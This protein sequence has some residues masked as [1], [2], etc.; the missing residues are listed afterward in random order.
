MVQLSPDNGLPGWERISGYNYGDTTISG[1]S[2]THL[3]GAGV[4]DLYDISFMPVTLPYKEKKPPLGI[5]S[6]F[7]HN[8]EAAGAG[9]YQVLLK[10]YNINVELTATTRC[11]IQRY[12]FPR[13]EAAIFLNLRKSMHRDETLDSHIDVL[14]SRTIRGYRISD[15]WSHNQHVYF[16]TRF[17]RP[18]SAYRIDTIPVSRAGEHIGRSVVARFDFHTEADEQIIVSTA[19][20]AVSMDGAQANLEEEV[21]D[22]DF[23]EYLINAHTAWNDQLDKIEVSGN[24]YHDKVKFYTAMYHSMLEPTTY[25]DTNGMYRGPGQHTHR[26]Y[27]WVNYTTFALWDTYRAQHPFYALVEPEKTNDIIKSMI[28]FYEQSGSLPAWSLFG[29]ETNRFVGYHATSVIADAYMKDIGNFDPNKALEACVATANQ[30]GFRG[31]GTYKRL[32]YVPYDLPDADGDTDNNYALSKT[33]AYAYDDYCI[34]RMAEK[35]GRKDIAKEFYLRAKNYKNLYNPATDFIQPRDSRGKFIP[36]FHPEE[37]SPYICESNAWLAL[38]SAQHDAEGLIK[39]LGGSERFALKLDS[40]FAGGHYV[41]G[42]SVGYHIIYLYNL[43][44]QPWKTQQYAAQ[45]MRTLY[46]DTPDGLIS[47]DASGQMSA[48]FL[49]SAMGF[50]PVNPVSGRYEIGSPIFPKVEIHLANNKTFTV[51][52][53]HANAKN[54]YIQSVKLNDEPYHKSYITYAQIMAGSTLEVEMGSKPGNVWY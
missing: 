27:G 40:L 43:V 31:I 22:D 41:H 42:T 12:T 7:S 3:S 32:G 24:D 39:L 48:W 37:F 52:A 45:V 44:R 16:C 17:S 49:F 25:S 5:Y 15:G 29:S 47:N 8:D 35:M 10:D 6:T 21:P 51:I 38:W 28:A 1:F 18:F 50:Y 4:G 33:L 46:K 23:N 53:N 26:A 36:D 19:L 30:D 13:A 2:H 34:A 11:G 14:D 9:Y 20:S 54:I